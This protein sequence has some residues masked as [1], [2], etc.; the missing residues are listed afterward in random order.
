MPCIKALKRKHT[1]RTTLTR[2]L[3]LLL[4][5]NIKSPCGNNSL[6][7][8]ADQK[9]EMKKLSSF[10]RWPQKVCDIR[11]KP[12]FFASSVPCP[13]INYHQADYPLTLSARRFLWQR[14]QRRFFSSTVTNV[15]GI[16]SSSAATPAPPH[17]HPVA[18]NVS[19]GTTAASS[20]KK[21]NYNKI[22]HNEAKDSIYLTSTNRIFD[23]P[24]GSFNARAWHEAAL[25]MQWWLQKRSIESVRISFQL[26]ER[27]RNEYYK[28]IEHIYHRNNN[29]YNNKK[30]NIQAPPAVLSTEMLNAIMNNWRLCAKRMKNN[31]H[32]A[33]LPTPIEILNKLDHYYNDRKN[34]QE[35]IPSSLLPCQPDIQTYTMVIDALAFGQADIVVG[36]EDQRM[37]PLSQQ[38]QEHPSSNDTSEQSRLS[39]WN[40]S[41]APLIGEALVDRLIKLSKNDES[42]KPSIITINSII[43]AW[44]RSCFP[45]AAEKAEGWLIRVLAKD[46]NDLPNLKPTAV[47]YGSVIFAW[48]NS[49][50][51]NAADR[52]E[53]LLQK[54]RE[55]GLQPNAQTY[56]G[57]LKAYGR[58]R[59]ADGAERAFQILQNLVQEYRQRQKEYP[60]QG[61]TSAV[62]KP[63]QK[64]F[65]VVMNAFAQLSQ[66]AR[67]KDLLDQL[68]DLYDTTGDPDFCP[69]ASAFNC[70]L[71]AWSKSR[72]VAKEADDIIQRMYH[73]A[74][75]TGNKA[76]LPNVISFNTVL[77]AHAQ[78]TDPDAWD[79]IEQIIQ[80]MHETD[81]ISP[82]IY[83]WNSA[84]HYWSQQTHRE[85]AAEKAE[86][87]LRRMWTDYHAGQIDVRPDVI[88]YNTC[89]HAWNKSN[90]EQ[91]VVHA[92][93]LFCELQGH[94]RAYKD[95]NLQPT[96]ISY[97]SMI[98]A[99]G[100][101][102][103][104]GS[105]EKAQKIF[106]EMIENG[107]VPTKIEYNSTIHAASVIGD[108]DRAEALLDQMFDAFMRGNK[109]A[110]P[111]VYSFSAI[112]NALSKVRSTRDALANARR[113]ESILLRME[114]LRKVLGDEVKPNT[115]CFNTVMDCYAKCSGNL[116]AAENTEKI[117]RLMLK[118]NQG[119]DRE[120]Q[121][122][123][124]SFT[125]AMNSWTKSQAKDA[126]VHTESL[127]QELKDLYATTN[128]NRY[129]PTQHTYNAIL[130]AFAKSPNEDALGKALAVFE[131]LVTLHNESKDQQLRPAPMHCSSIISAYAKRGMAKEAEAFLQHVL[132]DEDN[133][134][135]KISGD[136]T[137]SFNGL[138]GAYARS[139][140]P[141][142][143]EKA[144]Q[145]LRRMHELVPAGDVKRRVFAVPDVI[146]YTSVMS[147]WSHV[148]SPNEKDVGVARCESLLQEMLSRADNGDRN[149]MPNQRTF[150]TLL[151]VI[152]QSTLPDKKER[153]DEVLGIMKQ[154]GVPHDEFVWAMVKR[155]NNS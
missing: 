66:P 99:W 26:L 18:A 132:Y 77:H 91:A 46:E 153:A 141:Q 31:H 59:S 93:A 40:D 38:Q 148:Q 49:N 64:C 65:L 7:H 6:H 145:T 8:P 136:F 51:E 102:K 129:K 120:V 33:N 62:A 115:F 135:V 88:S 2:I 107:I 45:N 133:N 138:I 19:S 60:V 16:Y 57:I 109:Q 54:M 76:L 44:S 127:F 37:V 121:P 47:T 42:L 1:I 134:D 25:T 58:T 101:S 83:S 144:E 131:E 67:A 111:D 105:G 35:T 82:N 71:K 85:D 149:I 10:K 89:I 68:Q 152:Y 79:R 20:S 34:K 14:E 95:T 15:N 81:G 110:K 27:L 116:S 23:A 21:R 43:H 12:A 28:E 61:K 87:I 48:S 29:N 143:G 126:A 140:D 75:S 39:S 151:E 30:R 118:L 104:K 24:L 117:L 106:D 72:G 142:R 63:S 122:N 50:I 73:L 108:I 114:E 4:V 146:S 84:L 36:R 147:A 96:R 150:G 9:K 154:C 130:T 155:F 112:L 69:D 52:A 70:V 86:S 80:T 13:K 94:Y 123:A 55:M 92:N 41:Q 103:L 124:V 98:A 125:I 5:N 11:G 3:P 32:R 53:K 74:E 139:Q 78:S 119:G 100:K 97:G 17:P 56:L 113:A 128:D 22:H 90:R 137:T